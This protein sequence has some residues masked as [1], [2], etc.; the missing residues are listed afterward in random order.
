MR[1]LTSFAPSTDDLLLLPSRFSQKARAFA[2][3]Y[4]LDDL[5]GRIRGPGSIIAEPTLS[6]GVNSSSTNATKAF[7]QAVKTPAP[8]TEASIGGGAGLFTW[9][10]W[11]AVGG[12]F[13]Y[14]SSKWA[15]VT[16]LMVTRM[17]VTKSSI[18]LMI[19]RASSSIAPNFTLLLVSL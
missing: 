3:H 1:N 13:T 19:H 10:S 2:Y 9:Q 8:V 17:V 6:G 4:G 15:I 12:V 7:V 14:L 18:G 5:F 11:K 16:L